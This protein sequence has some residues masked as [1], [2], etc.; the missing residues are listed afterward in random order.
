[1]NLLNILLQIDPAVA[2]STTINKIKGATGTVSATVDSI[3]ANPENL[4]VSHIANT[5]GGIDWGGVFTTMSSH[6]MT[7]GFRLLAAFA[8]F[9]LG[10]L[11]INRLHKM[12]NVVMTKKKVEPSL[13]TFLLSL[14]RTVLLFLLI[15]TVVAILGIE[16]S[17]FI[18]IF[19]SAGVAVGLALSGTLQNFAGGVLILLLKPF[20]VGDFIVA[21]G[22]SGVVKE[23]K[24]FNTVILTPN[25]ERIS[26]PNGGLSTDTI[27]NFSSEEFRRVEWNVSISYGDSVDEA[28]R[29]IMAM[30]AADAL[31]SR[32]DAH[33]P[34]VAVASLDD[35]AVALVVRAWCRSEHY[36][37]LFYCINETI[38]NELPKHGISF[39]FPQLDVHMNKLGL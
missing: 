11:I 39:P 9:Y 37:D 19:A 5:V 27:T 31:V 3:V 28:R 8:V 35:S 17:S 34:T 24:I 14:F 12:L 38:Y 10:R 25:N 21:G 15:I 20:K 13:S 23:I 16:T 32:L 7:F 29:A 6:I 4:S 1:M 2:D 30:L 36:W 18:A 22:N 26:I 33:A